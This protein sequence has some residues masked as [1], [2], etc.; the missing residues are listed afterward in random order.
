M[1]AFVG[2]R[3]ASTWPHAHSRPPTHSRPHARTRPTAP[4]PLP[5][6]CGLG[7][8]TQP[9]CAAPV[10]P[11]VSAS[12][13]LCACVGRLALWERGRERECVCACACVCVCCARLCV[14]GRPW[15]ISL[16]AACTCSVAPSV[17]VIAPLLPYIYEK[18]G[19]PVWPI[20]TGGPP[21][22]ASLYH[23]CPAVPIQHTS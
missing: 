14:C 17:F 23:C 20:A 5:R 3:L 16:M 2:P 10:E 8:H 6:C 1:T 15:R 18:P 12:F 22:H 13:T 19:S 9:G 11:D 21:L 7:H 4:L